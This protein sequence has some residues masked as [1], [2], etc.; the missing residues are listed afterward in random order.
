MQPAMQRLDM[1]PKFVGSASLRLQAYTRLARTHHPDKGGDAVT[2][3]RIQHAYTIL[4]DPALRKAHGQAQGLRPHWQAHHRSAAPAAN[5]ADHA[6]WRQ[7][8]QYPKPDKPRDIHK[9][10]QQEEEEGEGWWSEDGSSDPPAPAGTPAAGRPAAGTQAKG[11][12]AG[13]TAAAPNTPGLTAH[14]DDHGHSAA[15]K[16]QHSG[17]SERQKADAQHD[18]TELTPPVG[19]VEAALLQVLAARGVK[20]HAA[21]QLVGGHIH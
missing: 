2:F 6:A 20:C 5:S 17:V 3:A 10:Q 8:Q 19:V 18:S 4:R 21:T 12:E 13:A 7:Q 11:S 15:T 1:L 9:Q 14:P 16:L